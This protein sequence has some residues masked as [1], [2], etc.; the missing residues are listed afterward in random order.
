MEETGQELQDMVVGERFP[1]TEGYVNHVVEEASKRPLCY[2]STGVA[3]GRELVE[4]AAEKPG[5]TGAHE[6]SDDSYHIP[7]VKTAGVEGMVYDLLGL[8]ITQRS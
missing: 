2:P 5:L 8:L 7:H 4:E 6:A 1:A 3:V